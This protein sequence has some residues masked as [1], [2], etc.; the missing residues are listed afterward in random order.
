[1]KVTVEAQ[2]IDQRQFDP[3]TE[4]SHLG[5]EV[6]A[7]PSSRADVRVLRYMF[8]RRVRTLVRK[9]ADVGQRYVGRD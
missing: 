4:T 5:P 1:M 6:R 8:E 3:G 2:L 7:A 9:L